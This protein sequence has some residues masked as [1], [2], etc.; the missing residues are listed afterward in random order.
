[1]LAPR[2]PQATAKN[3]LDADGVHCAVPLDRVGIQSIRELE[4]LR[5]EGGMA[6]IGRAAST[7]SLPLA[8][9]LWCCSSTFGS[10]PG[11]TA[12]NLKRVWVLTNDDDPCR[13]DGGE[14]DRLLKRVEDCRQTGEQIAL[15]ALHHAGGAKAFVPSKLW[16]A[17]VSPGDDTEA[18]DAEAEE[19]DDAAGQSQL[20]LAQAPGSSGTSGL[21]GRSTASSQSGISGPAGTATMDGS[22]IASQS[23]LAGEAA[24]A[25]A[26]AASD[27]GAEDT[28]GLLVCRPSMRVYDDKEGGDLA[29][30]ETGQR[31]HRKRTYARLPMRMPGGV[32]LGL[33]VY[34]TTVQ[35]KLPAARQVEGRTNALL[36]ASTA[37]VCSVTGQPLRKHDITRSLLVGKAGATIPVAVDDM[38]RLRALPA[39]LDAADAATV[40]SAPA[41]DD[42]TKLSGA[43]PARP[44]DEDPSLVVLSAHP[45]SALRPWM[46][47]RSPMF[48]F[49]SEAAYTGSVGAFAAIHAE[50]V[51]S[52]RILLARLVVRGGSMPRLVAVVPQVER[53]DALLSTTGLVALDL[54]FADDLRSPTLPF[55][56]PLAPPAAIAAAREAVTKINLKDFSPAEFD[57]PVLGRFFAMAR[58]LALGEEELQWS[59][60]ED[61]CVKPDA[62]MGQVERFAAPLRELAALCEEDLRPASA[63]PSAR[64]RK[65]PADDGEDATAKRAKRTAATGDADAT[66][67]G[68]DWAAEARAGRVGKFTMPVLKAKLKALG[69]SATGKKADL[70]GRLEDHL[71]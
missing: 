8:T 42:G 1:V 51:R 46:L 70:V 17:V 22:T 69:L 5:E 66:A 41:H 18:E 49:P 55:G 34:L 37:W 27:D 65:R 48:L 32:T 12:D 57:S 36:K 40:A 21:G 62:K 14:R 30:L 52:R 61:D 16:D 24:A 15:W 56:S 54:T 71:L 25:A 10:L 11:G 35:A 3:A 39:E 13:G 59:A 7:S 9:G 58:C 31:V 33:C 64:A 45:A 19:D 29:M 38:P 43:M 63:A 6:T 60:E 20:S 26:A 47:T 50:L 44:M 67:A 68:M 28:G 53:H 23:S 4:A 2:R